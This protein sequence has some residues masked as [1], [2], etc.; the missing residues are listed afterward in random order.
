MEH[1]IKTPEGQVLGTFGTYFREERV[2][3]Q[4]EIDGIRLLASAVA[5]VLGPIR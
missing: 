2:P 5:M 1:A 4:R 3:H